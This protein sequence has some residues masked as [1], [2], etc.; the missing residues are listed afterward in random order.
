M[1][2]AVEVQKLSFRNFFF[3]VWFIAYERNKIEAFNTYNS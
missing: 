1:P 2:V 3:Y